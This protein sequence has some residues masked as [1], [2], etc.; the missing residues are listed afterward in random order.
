MTQTGIPYFF[1]RGG[2]SRGPYFNRQ[3]LPE[4]RDH[5]AEVL[6]A[7]LVLVIR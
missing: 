6:I 7:A 3:D 4:D 1:M 5:L 2:S